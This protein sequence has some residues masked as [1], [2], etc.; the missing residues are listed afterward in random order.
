MT[1]NDLSSK[2]SLLNSRFAWPLTMLLIGVSV[3]M[4][5]GRFVGVYEHEVSLKLPEAQPAEIRLGAVTALITSALLNSVILVLLTAFAGFLT[6]RLNARLDGAETT[7]TTRRSISV[8]VGLYVAFRSLGWYL[9]SVFGVVV[10]TIMD[11]FFEADISVLV[12]YLVEFC[13]WR[14]KAD[15]ENQCSSYPWFQPPCLRSLFPYYKNN[16]SSEQKPLGF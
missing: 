3:F 5:M 8:M 13:Y 10:P 9:A 14:A 15:R 12:V 2:T 4:L 16:K 6:A 7:R 11:S 1:Q